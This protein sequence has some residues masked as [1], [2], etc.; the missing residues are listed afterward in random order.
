MSGERTILLVDDHAIVCEGYR[1]LLQKQ[2]G[3]RVAGSA[4]DAGEAYR[5]FKSLRP[6]LV[7]MDLTMPGMGGIEGIGRIRA[8][9]P[10]AR[11]LVLTM[12][13]SAAFAVQ[14]FR[15]GARG[16]VTKS[17]PPQALVQAAF[18]VLAG[19]TALS[20][21]IDHALALSR[22]SGQPAAAEILS[23]REF[24]ILRMLLD[25]RSADEIAAALYLS[26]KTVANTRTLIRGKLGVGSDIALMRLAMAQGLLRN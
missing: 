26:P 25:G 8:W 17:S 18:E 14:A 22:L 6:D 13:E 15:A 1:S 2:P 24:E 10:A 11:I 4:G 12:H 16:Y 7:I 19:R 20:P 5:L 21:D 9:D 3:L 23:P